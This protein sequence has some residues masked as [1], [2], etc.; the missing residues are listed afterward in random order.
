MVHSHGWQDGTGCG[1]GAQPWLWAR[2]LGSPPHGTL[3]RLFGLP[4]SMAAG[5]QEQ[6]FQENKMEAILGFY[7]LPPEVTWFHSTIVTNLPRFKGKG[8]RDHHSMERPP[9]SL[10]EKSMWD[11]I[12]LWSLENA[13][14][15]KILGQ[16]RS[17]PTVNML[18]PFL[19]L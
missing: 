11:G 2:S 12:L 7:S 3:H 17:S 8:H 16:G 4:L 15:H 14:C 13:I 9:K 5:F 10:Y 6:A 19:L 1:L 18:G